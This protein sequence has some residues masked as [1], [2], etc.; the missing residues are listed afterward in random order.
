MVFHTLPEVSVVDFLEA[1]IPVLERDTGR[2]FSH[3]QL[4]QLLDYADFEGKHT[5]N[6]WEA[7]FFVERVWNNPATQ[8]AIWN[9]E[10]ITPVQRVSQFVA[11]R[12]KMREDLQKSGESKFAMLSSANV[13]KP[14]SLRDHLKPRMHEKIPH[15]R[16]L[17]FK[18]ECE[19]DSRGNSTNT[20]REISRMIGS[21]AGLGKP[22]QMY[23]SQA[24]NLGSKTSI[25][26]HGGTHQN[27]GIQLRKGTRIEFTCGREVV[28]DGYEHSPHYKSRLSELIPGYNR[29]L[30]GQES[31]AFN[32]TPRTVTSFFLMTTSR[33]VLSISNWRSSATNSS[34]RTSASP[35]G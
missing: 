10:F 34:C 21:S 29:I 15:N 11:Y 35:V 31:V 33:R 24:Q 26:S 19:Q 32:L 12:K 2:K 27:S 30:F 14:Y 18:L 4:L 17:H 1:L 25:V 9:E 13:F 23:T 5:L 20:E 7:Y 28:I 6:R 8:T 16:K 22:Y 3:M